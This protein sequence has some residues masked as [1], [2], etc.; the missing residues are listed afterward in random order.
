M[1]YFKVIKEFTQATEDKRGV[2]Q[3]LHHKKMKISEICKELNVSRPTVYRWIKRDDTKSKI[4]QR[5]FKLSQEH[6]DF[7]VKEAANS[8]GIKNGTSAR[9][10]KSKIFNH[11]GVKVCAST[12]NTHLN[13]LLT[14]QGSQLRHFS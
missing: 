2:I 6:C 5:K 1:K 4:R 13:R 14:N 12:I 11:F 8:F 7:M 9:G 10:M 3:Y